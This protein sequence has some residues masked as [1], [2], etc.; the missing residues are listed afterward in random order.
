MVVLFLN[1][2]KIAKEKK[3]HNVV[4][5]GD[6][7][8]RLRA[9]EKYYSITERLIN[10]YRTILLSCCGNKDIL[11]Y[12][13]GLSSY[14]FWLA[15]N[16]AKTAKGIDISDVA[17]QQASQRAMDEG[18]SDRMEFVV[19]DAEHLA[20]DD[21]TFDLICGNGIIHHLELNRA[22]AELA[23]TVRSDGHVVFTEPLGHNFLI[24][25][26]RKLTPGIRTEDEHP[27]MM[28]DIRLAEKYF[29]SVETKYFYLAT[30][31]ASPFRKYRFFRTL[32]KFLDAVDRVLFTLLPFLK[33]QAWMA[34]IVL[35]D[36]IK[37]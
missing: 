15:Q 5:G 27:L 34:V 6:N 13:C 2:I 17:I 31:A 12:G 26:Y 30:L 7:E 10:E 29:R 16:G 18:L 35:K 37:K 36:P 22:Y 4:F 11:E 1:N 33:K 23:R 9:N 28:K 20:F 3:F 21:N 14:S 19:M 25:L 8:A 32:V 24:N